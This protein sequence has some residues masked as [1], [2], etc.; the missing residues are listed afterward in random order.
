MERFGDGRTWKCWKWVQGVRRLNLWL[1]ER[2]KSRSGC[3]LRLG[4]RIILG[5]SDSCYERVPTS[6]MLSGF[7]W[8]PMQCA[9]RGD[10]SWKS[11]HPKGRHGRKERQTRLC[12]D[13]RWRGGLPPFEA[14]DHP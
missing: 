6:R 3:F 5:K 7:A 14:A 10:V 2:A 8:L 12:P 1:P 13:L 4:P 9:N 11:I